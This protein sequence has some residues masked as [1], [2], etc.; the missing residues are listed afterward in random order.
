[1]H[2]LQRLP[3]LPALQMGGIFADWQPHLTKEEQGAKEGRKSQ[4][5]KD[6]VVQRRDM[7]GFLIITLR[8]E[9]ILK[10]FLDFLFK[11]KN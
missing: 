10:Q 6:G 4:Q 7:L 9:S 3:L 2:L 1:M 11:K 5:I 8:N